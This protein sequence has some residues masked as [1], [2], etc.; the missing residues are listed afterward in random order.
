NTTVTNEKGDPARIPTPNRLIE[1]LLAATSLSQYVVRY[2]VINAN[3]RSLEHAVALFAYVAPITAYFL[4][5][6]NSSIRDSYMSAG[7]MAV[8]YPARFLRLHYAM[9]RIVA[10]AA[11]MRYARLTLIRQEVISLCSDIIAAILTF[12]SLLHSGINW[13]CQVHH[14]EHNNFSFLDAIYSIVSK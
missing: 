7:V 5:I 1:L 12:S 10:I 3:H 13:Y 14:I 8:F 9:E 6:H 2:V 4:S 11:S